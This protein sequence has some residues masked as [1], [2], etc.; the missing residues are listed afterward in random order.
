MSIF[1]AEKLTTSPGIQYRRCTNSLS[2][3]KASKMHVECKTEE[4]NIGV[5]GRF[6]HIRDERE[7]QDFYFALCEIEVYTK[8]GKRDHIYR[9]LLPK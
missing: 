8:E 5:T 6:I 4:G 7:I 2:R 3:I 1:V 9:F